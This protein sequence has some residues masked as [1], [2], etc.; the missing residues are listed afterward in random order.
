MSANDRDG[1]SFRDPAGF[2]FWRDGQP[3]RHIA[4]SFA[5]DWEAFVSSGLAKEL[6]KDGLMIHYENVDPSLSSGAYAV[7]KPAKINFVSYPYEWSFGQLQD[8]ALLTLELQRRAVAK[9]LSLRDASAFNITFIDGRPML[10]DSLSFERLV[11]GSPWVAYGQ[12]CSHFLAPLALMAYKDPR[13]ALMLREAVDGLDLAFV[14]SLLPRR[15]LLNIGLLSHLHLHAR[16]VSSHASDVTPPR[17]AHIRPTAAAGLLDNLRRT[18]AA[19]SYLPAGTEWADY[20][21]HTSYSPVAAAS[22]AALVTSLLPATEQGWAWDLG[23][24]TGEYSRLAVDAGYRVLSADI[25]PA[26]VERHYRRLK[27]D[28]RRDTLPIVLDLTNPSPALGWDLHERRSIIERANAD[29]VLALALVHHLAIGKNI[30]L[31]MIASFFAKLA[32]ALIIEFVPKNDPMVAHLLLTR[33]DIFPD[34]TIGGFREAFGH[35]YAIIAERQ[36]E[37]SPRTLFLMRRRDP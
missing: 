6:M 33:P 27:N 10:I 11:S 24:N 12:F 29:V 23:A 16:S 32:P 17:Q 18:V 35:E 4:S 26:A 14:A 8:A 25:D 9:G 34:Y 37:D 1:A 28:Q 22:K 19:L 13:A 3:Y 21:G 36:I 20:A 31:S 15:T 5:S 7:I 2:V 30:P